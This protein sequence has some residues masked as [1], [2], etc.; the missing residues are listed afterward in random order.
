MVRCPKCGSTAPLRARNETYVKIGDQTRSMG[1]AWCEACGATW[2]F[3]RNVRGAAVL[4]LGG[5]AGTAATASA[6]VSGGES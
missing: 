2:R 5:G 3:A 4:C 6:A 1:T